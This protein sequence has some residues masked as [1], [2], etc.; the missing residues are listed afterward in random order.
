MGVPCVLF[1]G[2]GGDDGGSCLRCR[3]YQVGRAHIGLFGVW[4]RCGVG[5]LSLYFSYSLA[6]VMRREGGR[7]G[8]RKTKNRKRKSV[9]ILNLPP[10][11]IP[12]LLL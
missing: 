10:F 7:E 9:V 4:V 1:R 6:K 5:V 2:R 8:Q 12:P 11:S 3:E